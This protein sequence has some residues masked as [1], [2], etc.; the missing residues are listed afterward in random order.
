[1]LDDTAIRTFYGPEA[2]STP[3]YLDNDNV[4]KSYE[5]IS[6]LYPLLGGIT[7]ASAISFL[8]IGLRNIRKKS[9]SR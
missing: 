6:I 8:M 9:A 4:T 3:P 1:M 5:G 7:L 2:D